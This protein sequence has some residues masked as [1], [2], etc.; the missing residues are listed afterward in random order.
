MLAAVIRDGDRYLLCQRP[1]HKRHGELWEFPGGKIE[2]GESLLDAARREMNEELGVDVEAVG[3]VLVSHPDPGS[4]FVIEFVPVLIAG[5]PRAIEHEAIRWVAPPEGADLD[6]APSDRRFWEEWVVTG[7]ARG[8]S[9]GPPE[10]VQAILREMRSRRFATVAEARR[11]MERRMAEYNAAP[12]AELGGLSP[13]RMQGLLSDDWEG[14]GPLVLREDARLADLDGADLVWNARLLLGA[15]EDAGGTR[16]TAAG[17]LNRAFV[18][19]LLE[20]SRWPPDYLE[21]LRA[22]SKVINEEQVYPL[23]RVRAV[24][25][26]AGLV[27]LTRGQFRVTRLGRELRAA[28]RA[29][30]LHVRLLRTFFRR[31]LPSMID[32]FGVLPDLSRLAPFVLWRLRDIDAEWRDA[33]ALAPLLLPADAAARVVPENGDWD[34]CLSALRAEILDPLVEFGLLEADRPPWREVV[35]RP[36]RYRQAALFGRVVGFEWGGVG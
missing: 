21:S 15:L 6:L 4:P 1:R 33:G 16:A 7:R 18:G 35:E 36:A 20:R 3:G 11:H 22:V 34:P 27:R 9:G 32:Q 31:F 29:G 26:L 10:G 24:L 25:Q 2:P 14:G 8:E 13:A 12:Q 17:N 28:E 30:T 5:A 23:Y 19:S